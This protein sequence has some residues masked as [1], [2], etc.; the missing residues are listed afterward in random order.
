MTT[1]LV[2]R[3]KNG[4]VINIGPWNYVEENITDDDTGETTVIQ[5]NP[6]PEGATSAEEEIVTLDDGGLAAA[7]D[8]APETTE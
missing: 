4:T 3:D 8:I 1:Q 7:S 6:L 2:I 5:H